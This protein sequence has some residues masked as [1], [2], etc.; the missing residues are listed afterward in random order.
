MTS[1]PNVNLAAAHGWMSPSQPPQE[2]H[3]H[4]T[5]SAATHGGAHP[6]LV[7]PSTSSEE[8]IS[9]LQSFISDSSA[10][11]TPPPPPPL[12]LRVMHMLEDPENTGFVAG[13]P[14]AVVTRFLKTTTSE[15]PTPSGGGG[16]TELCAVCLDDLHLENLTV[17][18]LGCEHRFHGDCIGKWL[19][20]KNVCPLCKAVGIE[21]VE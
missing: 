3:D 14:E 4:R 1:H 9:V 12:V 5:N 6:Q 16:D 15:K 7:S 8:L 20:K 21:I 2:T 17:G 11:A 19:Q 10:A 13:L 18:I